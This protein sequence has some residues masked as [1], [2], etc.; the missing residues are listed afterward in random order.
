MFCALLLVVLFSEAAVT[1]SPVDAL[2]MLAA[3]DLSFA[4]V[5]LASS[6]LFAFTS[7]PV[8]GPDA[9]LLAMVSLVSFATPSLPCLASTAALVAAL[10]PFLEDI[11]TG[12][13]AAPDAEPDAE[14]VAAPDAEPVA[15]PDAEPVA[16]P[17][18]EPVAAP[19]AEPVDPLFSVSSDESSSSSQ[20]RLDYC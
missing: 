15:A 9:P 1:A 10:V 14:P 3:D 17:D 6:F 11:D 4:T 16:A 7:E 5:G 2:L 19:D 18:A 20:E 12:P 13:V 8:A